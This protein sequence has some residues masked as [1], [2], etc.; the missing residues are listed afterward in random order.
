MANFLFSKSV[1]FDALDTGVA[2]TL[3]VDHRPALRAVL[4]LFS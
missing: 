2:T 1:A 4:Q 3:N